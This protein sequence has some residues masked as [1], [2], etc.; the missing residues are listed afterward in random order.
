MK[1]LFTFA[2]ITIFAMHAAWAQNPTAEQIAEGNKTVSGVKDKLA[3][4]VA[5][6]DLYVSPD[7]KYA[8]S[9]DHGIY[10]KKNATA[11][12]F[13]Y[14]HDKKWSASGGFAFSE[15]TQQFGGRISLS[16]EW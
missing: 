13:G 5:L 2:L 7:R 14:R 1:H 6:D 15:D 16:S 12:Q 9:L 4:G 3:I 10:H 11:F 8:I